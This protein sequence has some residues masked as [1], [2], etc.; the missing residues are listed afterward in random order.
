ME[1][2]GRFFVFEGSNSVGKT[3]L[4]HQLTKVLLAAGHECELLSFP[5]KEEGTLGCLVYDLHHQPQKMG[6][7]QLTPA[8]LQML[9]VA[10]HIDAIESKI[11]PA[12]NAG[13]TVILDR[14]WWSTKV[15]GQL[16]GLSNSLLD[17]IIA[18]ELE[19]W[20]WV[21]PTITFLLERNRPLDLEMPKYWQKCSKLYALLAKEQQNV[22]RV[23]NNG[24]IESTLD[25]ILN[26]IEKN[27]GE[28]LEIKALKKPVQRTLEFDDES[29]ISS[30]I[31][32]TILSSIT[33]AKASQVFDTYWKFAV[34]RQ[35]IFFRRLEGNNPPWTN[36]PIF[37]KHK[38][39]N[40][41]RAS[42]RVSQYLIKNVIYEP[43]L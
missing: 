40:A 14:F 32:L 41:Y 24:T 15:Y 7:N 35:A 43:Q 5:G 2:K 30:N 16:G 19:V 31:G 21:I 17:L 29:I 37:L 3:E 9:H 10:A 20:K 12:L 34:E 27:T 1:K 6:I 4:T 33:P 38:F 28:I 18:P 23:S 8:S 13:K 26:I 39:T 25:I 11:L 22:C 42:D 36:D